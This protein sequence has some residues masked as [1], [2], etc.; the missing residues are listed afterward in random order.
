ME[1]MFLAVPNHDGS[2]LYVPVIVRA[3]VSQYGNARAV[4]APIGGVGEATVDE[5]RLVTEAEV[6]DMAA[7]VANE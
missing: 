4:V 1:R 7:K 3:R 6:G 5:R 2:T